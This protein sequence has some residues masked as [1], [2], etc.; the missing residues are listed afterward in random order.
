M[1]NFFKRIVD[2]LLAL[3]SIFVLIPF[4]IPI[5][6]GLFFTGEGYIWFKQERV[7]Y[8]NKKFMIW[9]FATMLKDSENMKGGIITITNDSRITPMGNFLRKS[10]IN[11]LPQLINIL[12]GEMS[13]IGPRPVMKK[14]FDTYP[15]DV[16]NFIY[17]VIPGL[18]GLG[19]LVFRDE[20]K[21]ITNVKKHGIDTWEYYK[22]QI[23]PY[24]GDLERYYQENRGF[25]ID[26][27]IFVATLLSVLIPRLNI[28][29]LF[30]PSAPKKKISF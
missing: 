5:M 8:K 1:Y 25:F 23:H 26:L 2:F 28:S 10:K 3:I 13:F 9:K 20:E 12:K 22:N 29:E 4:M 14:S 6:I 30:F 24:K 19:S 18:S 15:N 21:I 16:K 27:K 11:E 17:D 7:G